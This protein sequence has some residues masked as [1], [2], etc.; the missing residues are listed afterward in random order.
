M[1]LPFYK[2][3]H[4]NDADQ[5]NV[6]TSGAEFFGAHDSQAAGDQQRVEE[7]GVT[8]SRVAHN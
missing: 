6:K 2:N 1:Q 7:S 5:D 8:H 3:V 4:Q